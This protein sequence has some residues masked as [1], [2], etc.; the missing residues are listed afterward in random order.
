MEK[1]KKV[2]GKVIEVSNEIDVSKKLLAL[3]DTKKQAEQS[4]LD[5]QAEIDALTALK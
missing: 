3:A 1:Y 5:I 2:D 4:V